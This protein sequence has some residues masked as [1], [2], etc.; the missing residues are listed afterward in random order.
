MPLHSPFQ[1]FEATEAVARRG[2]PCSFCVAT[3]E[4]RSR[5]RN[6]RKIQISPGLLK[7]GEG[8]GIIGAGAACRLRC[9][10]KKMGRVIQH[11]DLYAGHKS[12]GFY[13]EKSCYD[14]IAAEKGKPD[15]SEY[16]KYKKFFKGEYTTPFLK[17]LQQDFV[18]YD[19]FFS[20]SK[21]SLFL[22]FFICSIRVLS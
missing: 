17:F 15:R 22:F 11:E 7:Q 4:A 3:G 10:P 2:L 18:N 1:A 19:C 12:R 14:D 21:Y 5:R 20:D 6:K 8:S 13:L 9:L 16:E